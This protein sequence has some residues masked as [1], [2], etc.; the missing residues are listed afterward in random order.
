MT[1]T[2]SRILVVEDDQEMRSLLSE[3]LREA[4]HDVLAAASGGEALELLGATEVDVVVTDQ[5]MPG[6]KGSQLLEE[7]RLREP[8]LPVVIITAFGSIES[9]VLAIK[10]GAYHYVA[11]PFAMA[12]LRATVASALHERRLRRELS[13]GR[14]AP[15][16]GDSR[17]VAES[18]AMRRVLDL[19]A[20]AAAAD[21]PV[22][23]R[24]ESG[25]GKEV[26]ARALHAHS[27]RGSGRFIAVNCSAI[28]DHLLESHLFG[29][30]RGAY[31]DAKEERLGLF[32]EARGGTV[33]LDEIG[34]MPPLLQSKLLRVLQE[35]EVHPLGAPLPVPVDVRVVAATH[36]DLEALIARG[37]FR[38]DLYYRL[39]VIAI[40]IPPLRERPEDLLPL[41]ARFLEQHG[42]RLGR[43]NCTLSSDAL[44]RFCG[45]AWPG[46]VRELENVIERA[47]VLGRD[48]LIG[49]SDLPPDLRGAPGRAPAARAEG[50]VGPLAEAEREHIRRALLA[51]GG[52]K[53]AAARLLGLDRKTLYRK[54]RQ[55]GT[56]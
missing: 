4:G 21:T 10:A 25:T 44:A 33:L 15:A 27:A 24:G 17:I 19:V 30:R 26:L 53:T 35:K 37:Q 36:R 49:V 31:T 6:M 5:M 18:R 55:F 39:N 42:A 48:T 20:R 45:Y 11:K 51:V 47:L 32:Q 41:A 9:A 56:D 46:N 40:H 13:A 54:L 14:L 50:G 3:D 22:L 34:D 52:N 8:E 1:A 2:T 7:L 43:P 16:A 12:E 23:L 28:P 38:Q 29:H